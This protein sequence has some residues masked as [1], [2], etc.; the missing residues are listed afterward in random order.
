MRHVQWVLKVSELPAFR[1]LT[2][3]DEYTRQCLTIPEE[4][5][6]RIV[7]ARFE[8]FAENVCG[9]VHGLLIHEGTTRSASRLF[10]GFE[11]Q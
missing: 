9:F 11:R 7:T 6:R 5:G 4:S 8:H 10:G 2:V 3:I 1:I